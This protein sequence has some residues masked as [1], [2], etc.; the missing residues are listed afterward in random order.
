MKS[1]PIYLLV[2]LAILAL[3]AWMTPHSQAQD[4][5][6]H[7]CPA[8]PPTCDYATIQAAVDAAAPGSVIKIAAGNYGDRH[9]RPSPSGYTGPSVVTQVVYITKT[10]SLLG[11]YTTTDWA[12]ADPTANPTTL[13]AGN[14]GRVILIAGEITP[15][16][17]GLHLTGGDASNLGGTS[18][19]DAGGGVYVLS[20]TVTISGCEIYGNR[21]S[22]DGFGA[23]GGLYLERSP[24]IV[25]GNAIHDNVASAV[26]E[27]YG[28]GLEVAGG[29]L[30]IVGNDI[31]SNVASAADW[32]YGG[33]LEIVA[34]T[35]TISGN[36]IHDN[37]ASTGDRGYG[38]GLNIVGSSGTLLLNTIALRDNL[39][40]DNTASTGYDG[41]GGGAALDHSAAVLT[42]NRIQNNTASTA[43]WGY[44]GGL[45]LYISPI[46]LRG[47]L[48]AGNVASTVGWGSGG[49]L[50]LW[51]SDLT[52]YND[53][54]IGN[55]AERG[56][57]GLYV[58]GSDPTLLHLTIASNTGGDG[59]GLHVTGYS[60]HNSAV[61]LTN[62]ILA[63][64]TVA[65]TVTAGSGVA[66]DGVLWYANGADTG[67][68]G[69]IQ[70]THAHTGDPAFAADGYHITA[71]SEAIDRGVSTSVSDD[72][73]GQPRPVGDGPDLGAD[74]WRP[75]C[76]ALSG[77]TLA[78]ADAGL[79]GQQLTFTA[80]VAPADAST[81]ITYTWQISRQVV[82]THTAGLSD[83]FSH[84]WAA[85]GTYTLTVTAANCGA[86]LAAQHV[87]TIAAP[88]PPPQ[89]DFVARPLTGSAPLTV[90]FTSTVTG[91]VESYAW[92]F[93]DGGRSALPHPHHVY[94]DAGT[95]DVTVVV[96][97]PGGTAT[98]FKP[99]YIHIAA[100]PGAPTATFSATPLSGTVP[101]TVTF[102]AAVSGTVEHWRWDFGDGHAAFTGPQVI[103]TYE[104]AGAFDVSLTVSNTAGS[105]T[106]GRLGYIRAQPPVHAVYLPLVLKGG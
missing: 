8:G 35:A 43:D 57:S 1:L 85:T 47:N 4:G 53:A 20:A 89:V 10:V 39:I 12:H 7:V 13:D 14:A 31:Y 96:T 18:W 17:A 45:E 19:S 49:G 2:L 77:V 69:R 5:T 22:G 44:G 56:G 29:P 81:P 55:Q 68:A 63:H 27:G 38:G 93:G 97:G 65:V 91:T 88:P 64:Q 92:R 50:D 80:T 98:A 84:T 105:Y 58:A 16:I 41:Y 79:V 28:G 82:A 42:G 90:Y 78:G 11:G 3:T 60:G 51:G 83:Y 94:S 36:D 74:E 59:S 25:R 71:S 9:A 99:H 101:L 103:H 61:T 62:L 37:I 75:S 6:L 54:V 67:G 106:V 104:T 26:S 30:L 76:T 102:T 52:G 40:H 95:F 66:L 100:P 86:S 33:G 70:V 32:G 21:A 48:I 73:D 24:A 46:T 23:G 72:I 15:T 87:V 34:I